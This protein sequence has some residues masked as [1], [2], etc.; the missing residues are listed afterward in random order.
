[1]HSILPLLTL[2]QSI[3]ADIA[4]TVGDYLFKRMVPDAGR[5]YMDVKDM[6]VVE[7]KVLHEEASASTPAQII[8]IE[9]A[10][11]MSRKESQVSLFSANADGTRT[12]DRA[13]ATATVCYEDAQT[14][15]EEW[16]MTSHLV[17][18]RAAALWKEAAGE[19]SLEGGIVSKLSRGAVYQLFANVVDY[20]TRYRGMRQVALAEGNLEAAADILLDIDRHGTWHTPP[21]WIDSTFQVAGFVMNS[22]GVQ[23]DGKSA[24]SSR[25]YF[26]ITPGWRHFRL[27][28]PLQAG[29]DMNYRNYVRMFPVEGELGAFA[30]DIYLLRG[31]KVVGVC[32]GIKFKRVPR[33]LMPTMFPRRQSREQGGKRHDQGALPV[34][35]NSSPSRMP[36]QTS[37][38]PILGGPS[39]VKPPPVSTVSRPQQQERTSPTQI[40]QAAPLPVEATPPVPAADGQKEDPRVDS[41]LQLIADE[42][43]LDLEELS[44]NAAFAELGVDSLLSITIS[45][46]MRVELGIQVKPSIFLEC[47]TIRD[48][49][50]WIDR[51]AA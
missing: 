21:H 46:K 34:N 39:N 37:P 18:A 47:T 11:D 4:L 42:T 49:V 22:F 30:G 48:L 36:L 5:L 17:A 3:W 40:V 15:H 35:A 31:E 29:P 2:I 25:D 28:E 8:R 12:T 16:Q 23:G 13:F 44:D 20:G 7:A 50:E 27:A 51:H 9:G 10:L 24:G 41:C 6:K 45:E 43:G 1:M 33:A 14:W 26:Y 19:G 32:A 38:A